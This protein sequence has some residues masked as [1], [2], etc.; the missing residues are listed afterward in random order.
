[1]IWQLNQS[2][3]LGSLKSEPKP[4]MI[5]PEIHCRNGGKLESKLLRHELSAIEVGEND[6]LCDQRIVKMLQP[7]EVQIYRQLNIEGR[8]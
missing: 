5:L 8:Y 3:L 6:A 7:Y 2:N 4:T 1:M